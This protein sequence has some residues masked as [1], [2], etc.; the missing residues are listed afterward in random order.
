MC[1]Q[2]LHIKSNNVYRNTSV[3]PVSYVVPCGRC[4]SCR[5]SYAA[6]WKCRLWH[7]LE[8]TYKNGGIAVFLTF[9]YRDTT[10]P[11]ININGIDVPCFNHGDVKTFLN[12]LKV[13]MY[14]LYGPNSYKYFI[15]MEYGKNTKRQH[16]H[17]LFFLDKRVVWQDFTEL[18][19]SLWSLGFMFPKLKNG[20][21]VKDNGEDDS[22]TIRSAVKGALYVSKYVTKDLSF[23]RI[24][25]VD[26]VVKSDKSF[27]RKFGPKH[28]QS[29]NIGISILDKVNLSDYDNVVSFLA[30]GITVPYSNTRIPVPR[31]IKKKLLFDTVISDRIGSTGKYLYDSFP[32]TLYL[33]IGQILYERKVNKLVDTIHKTF[34]RYKSLKSDVFLPAGINYELLANYIL[35]F[36]N[37]DNNVLSAF[38]R[39]Y[40]G[41][42][43]AFSESDKVGFFYNLSKNNHFLK[44]NQ[45]VTDCIN[46]FPYSEVFS[47]SL[48]NAYALFSRASSYCEKVQ[49]QEFKKR[50]EER[51]NVRYKYMYKY[52][53]KYC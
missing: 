25:V 18:C 49:V 30:N 39:Y 6:V 3:S 51:D 28:Y 5:D 35:Y 9:T 20:R 33:S 37:C 31:Y 53:K 41:D 50:S 36:R 11:C 22:P 43:S 24:P 8:H 2:P 26:D 47:N 44:S 10:L 32:S 34:A 16:L 12:R 13:S 15:A 1:Y 14:R 29:N 42:I 46:S 23:Y 45:Y 4:D 19:R 7:E 21:Y 48:L 52:P 17:G 38:L 40:D 27:V